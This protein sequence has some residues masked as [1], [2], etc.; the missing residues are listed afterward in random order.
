MSTARG[1][2]APGPP[3]HFL[4][5]NL[6]EFR[7]DVLRL[8]TES[9]A[10]Y[11]DIVRC[12]LGP[13]VVHLLNHPRHVEHVLQ[14]RST[15][16]DKDTRSSATIKTVTGES[17]L[18]CNG[19][20]WKRQRRL[21]QPAFHHKQIAGF[22]ETMTTA[23]AAMLDKWEAR[24]SGD[25][26]LDI[27]SEMA[28]LTYSIVGQTLFSFDTGTD[29]GVVDKAMR[30][31]LPHIF[32]RLG[33][34]VNTP[35]WFPS[36]ANRRFRKALDGVDEVVF[37][38]ITEHRRACEDGAPPSDLLGMLMAVRDPETGNGLSDS[39]LRNETMTFLLAGHET[40]A[41]SLAWIF[42]LLS[43]NPEVESE[44]HDEVHS[45]LGER[46]PVL[47]DLPNLPLLK[48]VIQEAMRLF[49][50]IWIIERRVIRED[51]LDGYVVPA[52][53]A[54][55][56]SPYALHRHPEF[57][58]RPAEFDP[59]RF[60]KPAPDA[61]IPFGA[62]PRFCIGKEFA[63][64]EAHLITAMVVRD[65]QLRQVP[66]NPVEPQPDITLRPRHGLMMTL[67]RR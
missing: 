29:A 49:P 11:G 6:K 31:M 32:G 65:Y 17:L 67:H 19:E 43:Q 34:I 33:N 64:L 56:I 38:I 40:T 61:Y 10:T 9:T 42:H 66:G 52:G 27:A 37:R 53:S 5:G 12:R 15:N 55:V 36:P 51:M 16:Y 4:L 63:M 48:R 2:I 45:V 22:A 23:T 39:Q 46:I 44:L 1:K 59:S 50:P 24:S 41:N 58:E 62:G 20:F 8:V 28:R 60:E 3:G 25:G 57:W 47:Q 13:S 7:H 35:A 18:T 21:D 30:V 54:V 26:L 14:A